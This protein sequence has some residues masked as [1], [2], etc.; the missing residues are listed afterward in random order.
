M[1]N[2]QK[3]KACVFHQTGGTTQKLRFLNMIIQQ[4]NNQGEV[5]IPNACNALEKT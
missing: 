3:L 1:K 5:R 4:S 2:Q